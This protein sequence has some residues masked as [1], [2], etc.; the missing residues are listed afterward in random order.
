MDFIVVTK[1]SHH[2]KLIIITDKDIVGQKFMEGKLQ[3]DLTSDFYKGQE[4]NEETVRDLMHKGYVFHLT[5]KKTVEMGVK[6]GLVDEKRV[7]LVKGVPH[8]EVM[9]EG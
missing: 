5:G 4:E 6:E 3:L 7:L 1:D 8:A 9:V 2:G